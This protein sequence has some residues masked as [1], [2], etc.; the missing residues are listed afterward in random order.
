MRLNICLAALAASVVMSTPA[1]AQAASAQAEARGVVVQ[2]LTLA[3]V[4]DLDFG[5]VVGSAVAGTVSI[6]PDT[7]RLL[8]LK[9]KALSAAVNEDY[10]DGAE[11][12]VEFD[13]DAH[14]SHHHDGL[15]EEAS[16]DLTEE[17]FRELID[18][19][20]IDEAAELIALAHEVAQRCGVRVLVRTRVVDGHER[21]VISSAAQGEP[22]AR[23][24]RE[25]RRAV[26]DA[27]LYA[28]YVGTSPN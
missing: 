2:P 18:D 25:W 28:R 12:E 27:G 10:D 21:I 8:I 23:F 26:E 15:V 11:H 5:T 14:A 24:N 19:L 6:D 20:N 17:E 1:F 4:Q 7:V 16:E 22:L 9:A 13:G 3:R